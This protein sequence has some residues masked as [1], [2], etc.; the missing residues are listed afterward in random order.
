MVQL[1]AP[2]LTPPCQGG[3]CLACMYWLQPLAGQHGAV[4]GCEARRDDRPEGERCE[5][6][7]FERKL[8]VFRCRSRF[9]SNAGGGVQ[10]A[11]SFKMCELHGEKCFTALPEGAR[12]RQPRAQPWESVADQ[13]PFKAQRAT[14]RWEPTRNCRATPAVPM[15]VTVRPGHG[16][17]G[18]GF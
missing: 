15:R 2:P 18:L 16:P 8:H 5:A 9:A 7:C 3:T 10:C 11:K 4:V 12:P 13:S 6:F 17:L 1:R 14:T